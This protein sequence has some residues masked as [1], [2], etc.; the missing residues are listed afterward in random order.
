M[1]NENVR[2]RARGKIKDALTQI[3][4]CKKDVDELT[5]RFEDY[6]KLEEDDHAQLQILQE[7]VK[8]LESKPFNL[9]GLNFLGKL[10]FKIIGK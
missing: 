5:K 7:R 6:L 2:E 10:I 9:E 8:T 3:S 4:A 1:K